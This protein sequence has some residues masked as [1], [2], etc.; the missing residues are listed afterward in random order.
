MKKRKYNNETA[1]IN[2]Y[3]VF[4]YQIANEQ[5]PDTVNLMISTHDTSRDDYNQYKPFFYAVC[6]NLFRG[7]PTTST[8][9]Y[10]ISTE[11][12]KRKIFKKATEKASYSG[13]PEYILASLV[14]NSHGCT[15][16][17]VIVK[18]KQSHCPDG[19]ILL[20]YCPKTTDEYLHDIYYV[21]DTSV[22]GYHLNLC[23]EIA[24]KE[25]KP[26]NLSL[27]PSVNSPLEF[28][29]NENETFCNLYFDKN[30]YS[31]EEITSKIKKA[32]EE[33]GLNLEEKA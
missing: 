26:A 22:L 12:E 15:F 24:E 19:K 7:L 10:E 28:V 1:P 18:A 29:L 25:E 13:Y 11:R 30:E 14:Q 9:S 2:P 20:V 16:T 5:N 17:T 33:N 4:L 8:F 3:T 6:A 21:N 31:L 32:A 23:I 27:E